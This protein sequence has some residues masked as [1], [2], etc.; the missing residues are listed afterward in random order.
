[1]YQKIKLG[2]TNYII[3]IDHCDSILKYNMREFKICMRRLLEKI[4]KNKLLIVSRM[5]V[6]RN[7]LNV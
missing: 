4:G 5:G 6:D 1:M 3:S 2:E 7:N